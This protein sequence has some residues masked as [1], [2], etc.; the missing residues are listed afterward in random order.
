MTS[1]KPEIVPSTLD[2]FEEEEKENDL[3]EEYI[4]E[5]P[6]PRGLADSIESVPVCGLC[7]NTGIVETH[8]KTPYGAAC[9]VCKPCICPN[10]RAIKRKKD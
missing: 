10:G 8:A 2:D 9:G 4:V 1:D 5:A 7:G 6:P 3:W